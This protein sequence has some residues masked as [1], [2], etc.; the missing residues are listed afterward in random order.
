M[1]SKLSAE[2]VSQNPSIAENL[3]DLLYDIGKSLLIQD[4]HSLAARWMQRSY[5]TLSQHSL[6][7]LGANA[8]D[9]RFC[10]LHGLGKYYLPFR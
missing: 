10:I 6:E 2:C 5:E 4:Q 9:L 1:L 8:G 3:A 7:K